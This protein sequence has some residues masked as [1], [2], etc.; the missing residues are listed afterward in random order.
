MSPFEYKV[1]GLLC[2][3]ISAIFYEGKYKA[4]LGVI[5]AFIAVAYFVQG[6]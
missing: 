1:L 3:N 2:V 6:L 4:L 5:W